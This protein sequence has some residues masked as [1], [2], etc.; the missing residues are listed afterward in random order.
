MKTLTL[1]VAMFA[2]ACSGVCEPSID[3]DASVIVAPPVVDECG[4]TVFEEQPSESAIYIKTCG[5]H[6][7]YVEPSVG[8]VREISVCVVVP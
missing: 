3:N 5:N 6:A 2:A 7:Q 1:L 8:V 4:C